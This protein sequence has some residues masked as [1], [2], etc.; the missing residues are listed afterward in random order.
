MLRIEFEDPIK[1]ECECCGKET[2]RL[3]RFVYSDNDAYAVYYIL[4]T[5]QHADKVVSGI[6]GLGEW[7]DDEVGP[8]ARLAFPFEIRETPNEFIVGLVDAVE[9]PWGRVKMLGRILN[10]EEALRHEWLSEVF[11]ITDHIVSDDQEIVRYF[12]GNAA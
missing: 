4:F 9:S 10:R 5:P 6:I 12:R 7:G 8:E 2:V 1:A 11:H 3:T